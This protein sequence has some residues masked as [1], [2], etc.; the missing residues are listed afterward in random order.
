MKTSGGKI[1]VFVCVLLAALLLVTCSTRGGVIRHDVPDSEY[2]TLADQFP[3]TGKLTTGTGVLIGAQWVLTAA[4]CVDHNVIGVKKYVEVNKFEIGGN[5]YEYIPILDA[6]RHPSYVGNLDDDDIRDGYDIAIIHLSTPVTNVEPAPLSGWYG[7]GET[8]HMVGYGMSGTGITGKT[9]TWGTKRAGTNVVDR[10]GGV[11]ISYYGNIPLGALLLMDFDNPLNK[12]DSSWGS[13]VPLPM[14][15]MAANGDSGGTVY[16]SLGGVIGIMSFGVDGP[17]H[18]RD[19]T[20][21][22][23]Y[24]DIT[25]ATPVLQHLEW[26]RSVVPEPGSLLMLVMGSALLFRR[27]R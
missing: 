23:D 19:G 10:V 11:A 25:G 20:F 3:A 6:I 14:E 27:R 15:I 24:G 13:D 22:S 7:L 17:N 26:I 1:A 16:D 21:N 9:G 2:L 4:H 12:G 18:A 8:V 5:T